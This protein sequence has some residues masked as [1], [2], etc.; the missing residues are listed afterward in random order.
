M[1]LGGLE[2]LRSYPEGRFSGGHAAFLGAEYRWNLTEEATP[3]NYFF[4]KDVR[5][6]KQIAFFAE[7][8]SVYRADL[9][10]GDEGTE[11]AIFFFYPW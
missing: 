8:G 6:G 7:A 4:W 1:S 5:T 2:R 9:S 10:V 3:F 11:V